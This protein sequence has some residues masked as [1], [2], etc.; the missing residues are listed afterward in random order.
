LCIQSRNVSVLLV[1][2]ARVPPLP[3]Q[4]TSQTTFHPTV[5]NITV[6]SNYDQI[7]QRLERLLGYPW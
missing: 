4:A 6:F 2:T 7:F 3:I 1:A 5:E